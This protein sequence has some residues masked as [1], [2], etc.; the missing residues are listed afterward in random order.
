MIVVICTPVRHS[1]IPQVPIRFGQFGSESVPKRQEHNKTRAF[2]FN[3]LFHGHPELL[4]LL[5]AL[6]LLYVLLLS[7]IKGNVIVW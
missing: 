4:V 6:L 7:V 5:A 1:S 3:N 2:E